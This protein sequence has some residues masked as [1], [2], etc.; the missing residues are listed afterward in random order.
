MEWVSKKVSNYTRISVRLYLTHCRKNI[1]FGYAWKYCTK[2]YFGLRGTNWQEAEGDHTITSIRLLRKIAKNN[3][4][5]RR[6]CLSVR[7]STWNKSAPTRRI[8]TNF[9]IWEFFVILSRKPRFNSN[10]TKIRFM[11]VKTWIHLWFLAEL[12][13]EGEIFRTTFAQ[14]IKT[15][16]LMFCDCTKWNE[17]VK[18]MVKYKLTALQLYNFLF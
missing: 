9:T 15:P 12:F 13:V 4:K 17:C 18:C 14:K 6:V 8:F 16:V 10:L 7:P 1:G 3:Y 5:L 11:Y 2:T